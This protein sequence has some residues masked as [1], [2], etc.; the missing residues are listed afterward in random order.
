MFLLMAQ[1]ALLVSQIVHSFVE[2]TCGADVQ[3]E[4]CIVVCVLQV[5]DVQMEFVFVV[6]TTGLFMEHHYFGLT[7]IYCQGPGLRICAED[8]GAA[9]GPRWLS[10]EA[11]D[12]QQTVDI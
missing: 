9:V 8:L 3:A 2:V 6:L 10:T 12:H 5:N 7:E 4:V 11:P 1:K